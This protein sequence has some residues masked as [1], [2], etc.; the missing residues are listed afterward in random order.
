MS[1]TKNMVP[2]PT[3]YGQDTT[4]SVRI[5]RF[6]YGNTTPHHFGNSRKKLIWAALAA[7]K[8][9]SCTTPLFRRTSDGIQSV[10]DFFFSH[11]RLLRVTLLLVNLQHHTQKSP[12]RSYVPGRR[13]LS[14]GY[15]RF[16]LMV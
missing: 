3:N 1:Y 7:A 15:S 5:A 4:I 10:L 2:I 8:T 12:V 11:P 16:S 14:G 6:E 9:L 13:L